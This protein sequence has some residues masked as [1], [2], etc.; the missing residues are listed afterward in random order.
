MNRRR[1]VKYGIRG[2]SATV[3]SLTLPSGLQLVR[4]Q[5]REC[6]RIRTKSLPLSPDS[7]RE[8][9]AYA[10]GVVQRLQ[11]TG[12]ATLERITV[13]QLFD[14]YYA[15]QSP[16]WREKTRTTTKARWQ[17]FQNQVGANT[18]ADLVSADTLD[19]VRAERRSRYAANQVVQT[20][21]LAKAVWR[22]AGSRRWIPDNPLAQ[23]ENRMGKDEAPL[24]VPEYSPLKSRA[25]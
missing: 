20:I 8:A 24:N 23:Y 9:K 12:S 6:G 4:V 17:C 1:I 13:A 2:A 15:A 18:M 3:F 22:L 21:S 25:S 19:E 14:R 5:W 16:K 11:R 10:K 7:K